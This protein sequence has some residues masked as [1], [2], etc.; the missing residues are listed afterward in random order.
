M[1]KSR[2][3]TL[4][5]IEYGVHSRYDSRAMAFF[6]ASSVAGMSTTKRFTIFGSRL[7]FW[8]LL[9]W[10]AGGLFI[11]PWVAY[12]EHVLKE[13]FGVIVASILWLWCFFLLLMAVM[14]RQCGWL[15][16][17][18]TGTISL[19]Y[20]WYFYDV[21]YVQGQSIFRNADAAH[22]LELYGLH[23][24]VFTVSGIRALMGGKQEEK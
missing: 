12:E 5:G 20:F 23:L 18:I 13:T 24:L 7:F 6:Q 8:L 17:F 21:Y 19:A 3:V 15:I 11:F 9:P 16:Y 10:A 1:Q 2:N 22:G 4:R 14:P